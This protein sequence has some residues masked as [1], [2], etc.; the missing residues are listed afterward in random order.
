MFGAP[1]TPLGA[2][3]T[4]GFSF[5]AT[6]TTASAP[7][8]ASA[9]ARGSALGTGAAASGAFAHGGGAVVCAGEAA[10]NWA[11]GLAALALSVAATG[12]AA[13]KK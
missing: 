8:T 11:F 2:A 13:R 12:V 6:P 9:S 10:K 5:G 4:G 1:A 7:A 3:T